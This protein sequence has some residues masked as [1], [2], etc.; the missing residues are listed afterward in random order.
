MYDMDM[1][2]N[3]TLFFYWRVRKFAKS[4]YYLRPSHLST[5]NNSAT[6][7]KILMKRNIPAFF[8]FENVARKFKFH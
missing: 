4:D 5:W 6:T 2:C 7:G 8:F 1:Q 3:Y